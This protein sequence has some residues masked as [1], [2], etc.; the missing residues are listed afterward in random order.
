MKKLC[1]TLA[2][3]L[4]F[5]FAYTGCEIGFSE[6][7]VESSV[8]DEPPVLHYFTLVEK[9]LPETMF[10][11]GYP[12]SVDI[13]G[14]T[15]TN[16]VPKYIITLKSGG[17]VV[18]SI[19]GTLDNPIAKGQESFDQL[20]SIYSINTVGDFTVEV[21]F[22]NSK[23]NKSNTLTTAF[24]VFDGGYIT[25]WPNPQ[26]KQIEVIEGIKTV[27]LLATGNHCDIYYDITVSQPTEL[28]LMQT[29][30]NCDNDYERVTSF[31]GLYERGGGPGG[32][33]GVDSNPRIQ[34]F[35]YDLDLASGLGG[36]ITPPGRRF[37]YRYI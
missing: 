10:P 36:I 29:V 27:A 6:P 13:S 8:P 20:I 11:I 30:F 33:G 34:I 15:F 19:V 21:Y 16:D 23:G 18:D 4:A 14:T 22:E 5:G 37:M 25:V 17:T 9:W 2:L 24:T 31:L 35:I 7:P 32:N 3:A 28:R 1:I 26:E 12:I